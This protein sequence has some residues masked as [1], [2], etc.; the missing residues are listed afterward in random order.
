[1]KLLTAAIPCYNSA[2]YMR[3]A[4]DTLLSGGDDMEIIIVNDGSKDDTEKIGLEYQEKY[5]SIVRVISQEN[6]GH[7]EAVNTGL[8][9]ATGLYFKVVDSDDWVSEKALSEILAKLKEL[10]ADGNSPDLFL[11]N[12]VYEKVGAKRKKVIHYN[13]ALPKNQIFTWDDIMHF[14]QS[15]NI[16]M[17]SAIYRTKLIKDC[18]LKLPKHTFYVDNIFVYQPLPYVK[19]MY[20]MDVNLYRYFIGRDDQSVNE[21]IMIKRIDQQ[22]RVTKI[23]IESHNLAQIKSK[24]LRNYM[25][26]YLSMM[27]AICSVFLIKEGSD[28]SIAKKEAL[29][30]YLKNYDKWLYK[31]IRSHILGRSMNLPGK[32]GRRVVEVGYAIT[33]K[34]YGFN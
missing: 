4:I 22:L 20:Y 7:G 24:K 34:I 15:Q 30:E 9:N 6:G 5:P 1:M 17:H 26:K 12:Y 23:M 19:T 31:R 18:G 13:R 3:H 28:E 8:A 16:L 32:F 27:M 2:E 33:R 29:W 25:I 10:I 11:A 14:K 21:K